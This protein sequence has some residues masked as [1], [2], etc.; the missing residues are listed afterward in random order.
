MR[1]LVDRHLQAEQPK[2][3]RS[4][5]QQTRR[6]RKAERS[7]GWSHKSVYRALAASD[8]VDNEAEDRAAKLGKDR[9]RRFLNDKILRE[10]AG[11]T[12]LHAY[13]MLRLEVCG[14]R[15]VSG[16]SLQAAGLVVLSSFI[17]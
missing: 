15:A 16:F 8:S 10:M 17:D 7:G 9:R 12:N 11:A 2:S 4:S 6:V 13:R 5:G 3:S 1:D 14:C